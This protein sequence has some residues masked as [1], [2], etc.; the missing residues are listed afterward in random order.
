MN[1]SDNRPFLAGTETVVLISSLLGNTLILVGSVGYKAVDL[2]NTLIVLTS[3]LAVFDLTITLSGSLPSLISLLEDKWVF[4]D[5]GCD[6]IY[7][8]FYSSYATSCCLVAALATV[9]W[10]LVKFPSK[11]EMWLKG[12][13][14]LL[15]FALWVVSMC[16][17]AVPYLKGRGAHYSNWSYTCE[18]NGALSGGLFLRNGGPGVVVIASFV[19]ILITN[20][21]FT[22][23]AVNLSRDSDRFRDVL[24]S[25]LVS[26]ICGILLIPF[27]VSLLMGQGYLLRSLGSTAQLLLVTPMHLLAMYKFPVFILVLPK[28]RLFLKLVRVTVLGFCERGERM[29]GRTESRENLLS[30]QRNSAEQGNENTVLEDDEIAANEGLLS[31]QNTIEQDEESSGLR[32][33]LVLNGENMTRSERAEL[34]VSYHRRVHQTSV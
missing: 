11:A 15:T 10:L 34:M 23:E 32:G 3:H 2:H 13:M 27:I 14:S 5:M 12:R 7:F 19:W 17:T 29:E 30:D 21:L 22:V 33:N 24:T 26:V 4:G 28:F 1:T 31:I 8:T 16:F 18:L 6:L 20:L 9:T 25:F